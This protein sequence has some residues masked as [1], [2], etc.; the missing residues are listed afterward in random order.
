MNLMDLIIKLPDHI[1]TEIQNK[2]LRS[3]QIDKM[4]QAQESG[5]TDGRPAVTKA[6]IDIN[7]GR[8]N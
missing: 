4:R 5:T 1:L 7:E 3:N 6:A 2:D 8:A